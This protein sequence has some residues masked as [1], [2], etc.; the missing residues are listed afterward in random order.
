MIDIH[1]TTVNPF[2]D[3]LSNFILFGGLFNDSASLFPLL[4]VTEDCLFFERKGITNLSR[5]LPVIKK[6]EGDYLL[7]IGIHA[8][9]PV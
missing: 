6:F 8:M 3:T 4:K 9:A 5:S 7:A 2:P 1:L